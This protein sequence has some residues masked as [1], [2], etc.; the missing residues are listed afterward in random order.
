M[1]IQDFKYFCCILPFP[2]TLHGDFDKH[3]IRDLQTH[4]TSP[5]NKGVG[6]LWKSIKDFL[7]YVSLALFFYHIFLAWLDNCVCKKNKAQNT[8]I[9][10]QTGIAKLCG[11]GK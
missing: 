11:I 3:K 10:N 9:I 8:K 6:S 4:A 1:S 7:G 5:G 2:G